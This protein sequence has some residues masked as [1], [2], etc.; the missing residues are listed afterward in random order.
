M[1][2]INKIRERSG[3]AVGVIAVSLILFIVGGDLL[4]GR[5]LLFGGDQQKIG[6][7]AGKSIAYPDFNAKVDELR[8][9]FEQ[10]SG[11]APAEQDLTQIREQAWNQMLFEIAYQEQFDKL[12]L[13][14]SPEELV[15]MVQGNNISPAVRQ[16]FTNPQTGV[17]DKSG[18]ISYLKGLKNLPPQQQQAWASFEKNLASDRLREKYEGL[19]RLSV[20]ATTAEAQKEYQAQNT[21][22]DVKFL[23]VPYYAINDT[24]IKV[25]DS[26]LQ[27]YLGK[28]KDA[29]PGTDSRSIQYVTFS[30]APSKEDSA[31]L[32]N[33]IKTLAR[34]L[35][36]AQNDSTFAQQNSDVRVPLYLTAG[37][38]PEQLRASIPT[39]S[40][41][42]IYGPFREGNTYFIYKYGGTKKDT[43]FTARASHILIQPTAKTDSAKADARRRAE[44]ILT[45]IQGGASFEALAQTNSADGSA[46]NGGDL[47]YFKNNGQMVK[48]FESAV[49]AATSAGLIPRLVETDF[50]FHIIKV[51]QPKTNILYRVA[52]I[53]K[54]ITPSQITR[55][56]ALR[57][58]DQFASD[59]RTKEAFDAKVKED[60][61][62][63]M[64]TAD[65][66]PES[67]NQ[68]NALTDA[69]A[70][71]RWAFD[72]KTDMNTVSDPF[73][74]GDQYVIA[75]LTGKTDKDEVTVADY[76]NE[77]TAKVRNQLKGEQIVAKLGN[78]SGSLEALA[79]KYGAGALVET[80]PDVNMATGF[81]RSAGVDPTAL[82]TA[83]GLKPGKRSK[84]VVGE[85]GVLVLETTRITPAPAVADY[86]IYKTQLQQNNASRTGFYINEAIKEAAKVEDR[87]AKFY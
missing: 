80:V 83:F 16:A 73:E 28:H 14:V 26:Q 41:G 62:L 10:Q 71:V 82:G 34:G 43:S 17:F 84:P 9:Q 68:I 20:F 53:A 39:F 56:E 64:A 48:P 27:D 18:I 66:I 85:S 65:R 30:V 31:T 5:S 47:G 6:E 40:P 55:D 46:Q 50:G 36:A 86:A 67:A 87:R 76:R 79:Q 13:K 42:G 57:K 29:Y 49:F 7:I 11:R 69:R 70:V 19:M 52:A 23:F 35:G 12:G 21:K 81:L 61:S 44:A 77:L 59:V 15:D 45:Q 74:I 75:V 38:M 78:A 24:T 1:S 25:T 2:V 63:V 51:T 37:E 72:D 33:E 4:G 8:A 32:Y 3:L 60:K 22:A 58:A 54:T